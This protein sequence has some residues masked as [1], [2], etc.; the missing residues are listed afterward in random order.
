MFNLREYIKKGFLDAVGK[1]SDYQIIL[2]S[3]GWMEKGVLTEDDLAEIN[4]K[5]EAQYPV[6]EEPVIDEEV[7]EEPVTEEEVTEPEEPLLN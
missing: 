3:A 6:I 7:T 1:M 4:A 2:N 5:I